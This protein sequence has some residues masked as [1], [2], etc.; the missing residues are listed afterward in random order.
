MP[1]KEASTNISIEVMHKM[2]NDYLIIKEQNVQV[3]DAT[4]ASSM[5]LLIG[6]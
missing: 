3:C 5:L 6:T 4:K 2:W 1:T